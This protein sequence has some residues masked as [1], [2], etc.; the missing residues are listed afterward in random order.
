M[1]FVLGEHFRFRSLKEKRNF[2]INYLIDLQ[3]EGQFIALL[4][5][6]EPRHTNLKN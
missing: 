5:A 4:G 2:A 3:N 6:G 1:I